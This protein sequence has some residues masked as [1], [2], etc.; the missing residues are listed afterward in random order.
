MDPN[1][2]GM[3]AEI[4]R[5]LSE[6]ARGGHG[7]LAVED[8]R[9]LGLSETMI[10]TRRASGCLVPVLKGV[11]KL[12]GTV[13]T[14]RG[15]F[16][17]AVCSA[18]AG[19]CLSRRSALA[20]HGLIR[21]KGVVHVTRPGGAARCNRSLARSRDETAFE[22]RYHQTRWL[23]DDHIT[24]VSGIRATTVERSLRDFAG[25][26]KK[27]EIARA[28]SQGERER[29]ICWDTLDELVRDSVGHA[30]I[31]RLRREV[32][33]WDPVMADAASDPEERFLLMI[34]DSVV[35]KPSTN[36]TIGSHIADF[37]WPALGLVVELDPY[38][39][40]RGRESFHRDHRKSVELEAMGL[41]VIRFTWDDLYRHEERT[42]RELEQIVTRQADIRGEANS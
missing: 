7:V 32:A 28:L 9:G 17:A 12:P 4:N 41:R 22:V 36:V 5:R 23:P 33:A 29:V 6:R 18:G 11:Y 16:R 34:R 3:E 24:V 40:H 38:G 20:L 8:L 26:A 21:S 13:L 1:W 25:D 39:T 19:A 35:P 37:Y 27:G 42:V 14:E 15:R 30:G 10:H 31:K 2:A